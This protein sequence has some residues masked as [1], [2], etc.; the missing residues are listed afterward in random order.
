MKHFPL[1][2]LIALFV[3]GPVRAQTKVH[4]TGVRVIDAHDTLRAPDVQLQ[5]NRSEGSATA[6]PFAAR[7]LHAGIRAKVANHNVRRSSLKDS[8]VNLALDINLK[9]GKSKDK[10]HVEKIFYM[11][12]ARTGSV[13]QR[14]NFKQGISMRTIVLSFD[15]TI[16]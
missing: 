10:K 4:I 12:Q 7:D 13:V 9:A 3:A 14:F 16:E 6:V 2:L 15:I 11:D 8:A 1:V 5:L